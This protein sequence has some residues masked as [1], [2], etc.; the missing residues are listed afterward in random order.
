MPNSKTTI[1]SIGSENE[2]IDIQIAALHEAANAILISTRGGAIVWVNRAFEEL[3]G[4]SAQEAIGR[5]TRLLKSGRQP[6][7]FYQQ[8]WKTILSGEKWRGEL[9]NRRKDGTLYD[10]EMTI[11]PIR[12]P[13]GEVSH[14][15]A[16][17]LDITLRKHENRRQYLLAQALEHTSE[18][19]GMA[20]E[21]GIVTYV[22]SSFSDALGFAKNDLVGR[23]FNIFLSPI[24]RG[25]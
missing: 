1:E 11:T 7:S 2:L 16:V 13:R 6:A 8:L 25:T 12:N 17:K 21:E 14:F 15:L 19:I 10:E 4:Y 9:V 22:N 5:D 18:L 20:N 3:S 24:I 23:H